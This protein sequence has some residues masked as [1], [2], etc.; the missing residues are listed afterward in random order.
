M[1]LQAWLRGRWARIQQVLEWHPDWARW[2]LALLLGVAILCLNAAE[3]KYDRLPI[4]SAWLVSYIMMFA[5]PGFLVM[6]HRRRQ[7]NT[8]NRIRGLYALACEMLIEDRKADARRLLRSIRR[9]ELHWRIGDSGVYRLAYSWFVIAA[10]SGAAFVHYFLYANVNSHLDYGQIPQKDLLETAQFL[11][12]HPIALWIIG[13][14]SVV[15]GLSATERLHDM[16][17]APWAEFYGDL[18]ANAIN[19]GRTIN[20]APLHQGPVLPL[21]GTA[22]EILGLPENFTAAELRRAWLRLAR[23]LHPDRWATAG[24]GVKRMKEGAL[25]RVNAARDELAPQAIG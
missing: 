5:L 11:Q 20:E 7:Q 10:T 6:R 12:T 23:E 22:R 8:T 14:F 16:K 4:T 1:R 9:W 25:K 24:D 17:G 3:R 15:V 21:N 13:I 2:A 19:A 18:L